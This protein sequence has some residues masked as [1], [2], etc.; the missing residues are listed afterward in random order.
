MNRGFYP[1]FPLITAGAQIR[2]GFA[3]WRTGLVLGLLVVGVGMVTIPQQLMGSNLPEMLAE[4]RVE[5]E[6]D[7]RDLVRGNPNGTITIVEFTD[8]LCGVCRGL[9]EDLDDLIKSDSRIRL[10]V[11]Q[12]PILG[13]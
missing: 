2:R 10:V 1:K 6:Q 9:E 8:Y 3:L 11:K 4:S 7:R 5:L 13:E 12:Y